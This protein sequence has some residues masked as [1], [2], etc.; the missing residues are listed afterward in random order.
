MPSMEPK[1]TTYKG[2][3]YRSRLEAR[4][5]VYLDHHP[6]VKSVSYER[7]RFRSQDFEYTP[8]FKFNWV[9]KRMFLEIKPASPSAEYVQMLLRVTVEHCVHLLLAVGSFY[10]DE[11]PVLYDLTK[12]HKS[13]RV[14]GERLTEGF[15]QNE[16]AVN[17]ALNYR[18]DLAQPE[19][20][21]H[22]VIKKRKRK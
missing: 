21:T 7:F 14:H 20:P 16:Y 2:V 3:Q 17:S 5:A 8:D 13:H 1:P 9:G 11:V 12:T 18:F 19:G 6:S 10:Q 4:W 15:L 22:A